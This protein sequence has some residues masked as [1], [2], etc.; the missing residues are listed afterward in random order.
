MRN[1][2]W[3]GMLI[4]YG[5]WAPGC[6]S[7]PDLQRPEFGEVIDRVPSLPRGVEAYQLPDLSPP[8]EPGSEGP[9]PTLAEPPGS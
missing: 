1:F 3:F 4:V 6:G 5:L 8:V 9:T 7:R 2:A